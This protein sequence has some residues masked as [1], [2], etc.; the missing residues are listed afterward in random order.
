M[1]ILIAYV[2]VLHRGYVEFFL[3]HRDASRLLIFGPRS[4]LQFEW[5]K[6]D[7]R[8]LD[9]EIAVTAIR[10]LDIFPEVGLL[11]DIQFSQLRSASVI[12]MPDETECHII[13]ETE[14]EGLPV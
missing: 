8:S 10:S 14:L 4:F 6:K 2:P 11:E 13:A 7:L 3:R 1:K 9:P 12:V 5:L